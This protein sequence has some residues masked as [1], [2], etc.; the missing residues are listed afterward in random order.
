MY[1]RDHGTYL[2]DG[3]WHV[4]FENDRVKYDLNLNF[5]ETKEKMIKKFHMFCPKYVDFYDSSFRNEGSEFRWT[6]T[7]IKK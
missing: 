3:L 7:G 6:F 4:K 1:Y 5:V 2:G